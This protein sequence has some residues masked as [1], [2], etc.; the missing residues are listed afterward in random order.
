MDVRTNLSIH[1]TQENLDI[2]I[3]T[4]RA[5]GLNVD[6]IKDNLELAT[7]D[8]NELYL[9]VSINPQTDSVTCTEM[10]GADFFNHW[11]PRD[12]DRLTDPWLQIIDRKL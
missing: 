10:I 8:G 9:V 4:V 3:A 2:A 11:T 5:F 12:P 6:H 1:V 7:E